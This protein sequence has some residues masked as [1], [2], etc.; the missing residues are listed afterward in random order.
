[1]LQ[2]VSR[3]HDEF[4]WWKGSIRALDKVHRFV[5]VGGGFPGVLLGSRALRWMVPR[6]VLGDA[7]VLSFT[8][9][10]SLST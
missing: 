3:E 6:M 9:L 8:W 1:M 5:E 7:V 4:A 10:L 2:G